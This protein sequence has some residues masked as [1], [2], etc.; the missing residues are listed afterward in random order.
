MLIQEEYARRH[1]LN[2]SLLNYTLNE[3]YVFMRQPKGGNKRIKHLVLHLKWSPHTR[4]P[5]CYHVRTLCPLH[6]SQGRKDYFVHTEDGHQEIT[7]E[8]LESYLKSFANARTSLVV[9]DDVDLTLFAWEMFVCCQDGWFCLN[10][11]SFP[12]DYLENSLNL[13]L[14]PRERLSFCEKILEVLSKNYIPLY[15]HWMNYFY[16]MREKVMPSLSRMLRG[17]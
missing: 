2:C 12:K 14:P 1:N 13:N 17:E 3:A 4:H 5:G 9:I 15:N 16:G 7:Y 6:N 8:H 10:S 11:D